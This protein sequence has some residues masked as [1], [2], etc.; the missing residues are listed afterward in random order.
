[1]LTDDHADRLFERGN[2][3][4]FLFLEEDTICWWWFSTTAPLLY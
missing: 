1:M 4:V 2:D 3:F